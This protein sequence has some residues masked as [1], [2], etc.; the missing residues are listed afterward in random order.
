MWSLRRND[1]HPRPL[2]KGG[3][4]HHHLSRPTFILQLLKKEIHFL[5]KFFFSLP[6]PPK[7]RERI[8]IFVNTG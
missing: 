2:P 3:E 6:D 5:H 1:T 7:G 8:R 4:T